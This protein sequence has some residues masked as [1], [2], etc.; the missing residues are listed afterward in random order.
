MKRLLMN[1]KLSKKILIAPVVVIVFLV[2][3]G[4]VSYLSLSQQ[5]FAIE[6]IFGT[7]FKSFKKQARLIKDATS[8]HANLYKVI[9]WATA[10]YEA[11][12][13]DELGKEQIKTM[14]GAVATVDKVLKSAGL[15]QGRE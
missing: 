6:E 5:K 13:I 2:I 4:V 8:V 10:N 3:S 7:R 1:L 15:H 12:K 11:K 14:E 9:D